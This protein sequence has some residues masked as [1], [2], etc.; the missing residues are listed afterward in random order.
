MAVGKVINL[1]QGASIYYEYYPNQTA[2]FKGNIIFVN[3]S[4]T[5][6]TE[7]KENKIFFNCAK[8]LGSVFLYDRPGL[9]KSPPNFQLSFKNPLTAK[10]AGDQLSVLL[11]RLDIEQPYILVAHSYGAMYSGYFTLKNSHAVKGLL[12][13][14][15]VPRVFNFSTKRMKKYQRGVEEAKKKSANYIYKNYSGSKAEVLYQLLGFNE[16]KQSIKYLGNINDSIPIIILSSTGMETKH[17]LAE[18]L[19]FKPKTMA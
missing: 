13:V 1:E 5:D 3:G 7:W 8:K 18:R 6:I 15:P 12:L 4:G 2:K 19:V 16:T 17:P 14:D 11:K 9:G 10:I